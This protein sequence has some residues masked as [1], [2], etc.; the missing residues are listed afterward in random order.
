MRQELIEYLKS[1]SN[2]EYQRSCWVNGGCP[3]GIYDDF[4]YAV[5]F[6][7]DDTSLAD[8]PYSLIGIFLRNREEA[9]LIK[10]LCEKISSI[11]DKHGTRLSDSDYIQLPEWNDVLI[12]S[13]DCLDFI[14][15]I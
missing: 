7:Y 5:H 12:L 10:A 4:D 2:K 13:K 15:S 8:D 11:F 6:F 14:E 9:D 3:N 1:L